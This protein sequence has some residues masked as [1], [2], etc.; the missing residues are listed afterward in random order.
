MKAHMKQEVTK[1]AA[2]KVSAGAK[3]VPPDL[4]NARLYAVCK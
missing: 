1:M 4:S 3:D 2:E